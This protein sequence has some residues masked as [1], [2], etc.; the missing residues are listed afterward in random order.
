M[1]RFRNRLFMN[2]RP[3]SVR[4][5]VSVEL[6]TM[7]QH[8]SNTLQNAVE[9]RISPAIAHRSSHRSRTERTQQYFRVAIC[10]A[11][12]Q[13]KSH[14]SMECSVLMAEHLPVAEPRTLGSRR[15]SSS[16]SMSTSRA[17]R[18]ARL[19][20]A[21]STTWSGRACANGRAGRS[22]PVIYSYGDPPTGAGGDLSGIRGTRTRRRT[23]EG[24]S[25]GAALA[26]LGG[27]VYGNEMRPIF[28][29]TT[30][31]LAQIKQSN[32][33]ARLSWHRSRRPLC[34]T[35]TERWRGKMFIRSNRLP[36]FINSERRKRCRGACHV[37]YCSN[38]LPRQSRSEPAMH[39]N[40]DQVTRDALDALSLAARRRER[41]PI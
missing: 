2:C 8:K 21:P 20:S 23:A 31:R 25:T 10:D 30:S 18:S 19:R 35:E 17:E 34:R 9:N 16:W 6:G 36:S 3:A 22:L 1:H 37:V 11:F 32:R 14:L 24:C 12:V 33:C 27:L 29:W 41:A 7:R 40:C 4:R 26:S 15:C 28:G 5:P 39:E 38:K 13:I